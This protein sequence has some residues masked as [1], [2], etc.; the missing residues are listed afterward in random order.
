MSVHV[1]KGGC[2][3]WDFMAVHIK[4]QLVVHIAKVPTV[5]SGGGRPGGA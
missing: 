2:D 3:S 1:L 4:G 5:N